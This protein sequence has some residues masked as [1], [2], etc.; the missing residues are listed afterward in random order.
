MERPHGSRTP[1]AGLHALAERETF[2]VLGD[3]E[4]RRHIEEQGHHV[5]FASRGF[6]HLQLWHPTARVSILTPS[7]LTH[8]RFEIWRDGVRIAVRTWD[9]VA[10][11]LP[12]LAM[13]GRS[14]L[15]ALCW[16]TVV[17]DEA[18]ARDAI[19]TTATGG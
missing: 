9:D 10:A 1:F 5:Y 8:D 12:D 16:W 13:P 19:A 14:E 11:A 3:W 17:R 2:A 18:E 4:V 7:R 6:L 15:A